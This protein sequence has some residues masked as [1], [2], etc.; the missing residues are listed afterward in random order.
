MR[1]MVRFAIIDSG[2]E[3]MPLQRKMHS[4]AWQ[5]GWSGEG[6]KVVVPMSM[7]VWNDSTMTGITL[8]LACWRDELG[9]AW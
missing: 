3:L 6:F 8:R 5:L 1:W 4:S 2:G 7:G 9:E